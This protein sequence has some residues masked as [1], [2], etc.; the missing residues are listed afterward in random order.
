[1]KFMLDWTDTHPKHQPTQRRMFGLMRRLK[2][3]VSSKITFAEFA[4]TVKPQ[5]IEAYISRL[6][7]I[8]QFGRE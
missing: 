3:S 5:C 7:K 1:M 6:D 8:N 4:Q 2:L